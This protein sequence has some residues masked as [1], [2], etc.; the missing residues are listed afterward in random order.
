VLCPGNV[1]GPELVF[2][3]RPGRG[4]VEV[5]VKPAS[6]WWIALSCALFFS[7]YVIWLL[8]IDLGSREDP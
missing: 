1:F 5:P 8:D 7:A 2:E 4:E 6:D 3:D